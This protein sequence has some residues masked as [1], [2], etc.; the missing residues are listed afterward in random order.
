MQQV[1]QIQ[2]TPSNL[3]P[4]LTLSSSSVLSWVCE[5]G[6]SVRSGQHT[7]YG[8]TGS[9][10]CFGLS[11]L[12]KVHNGACIHK[13]EAKGGRAVDSNN[14]AEDKCDGGAGHNIL[15]ATNHSTAPGG[16]SHPGVHLHPQPPR[17]W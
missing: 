1:L 7:H 2:A 13:Y 8:Q 16:D 14:S 15:R 4:D 3:L 17:H 10:V 9:Y 11:L 12:L 5:E 6:V